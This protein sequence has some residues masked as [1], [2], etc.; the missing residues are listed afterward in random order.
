M[1]RILK[2]STDSNIC[3]APMSYECRSSI[4]NSSLYHA[5]THGFRR[6]ITDDCAV[7]FYQFRGAAG[8]KRVLLCDSTIF[9]YGIGDDET[10]QAELSRHSSN[11]AL[12]YSFSSPIAHIFR[13]RLLLALF[14]PTNIKLVS[15]IISTAVPVINLTSFFDTEPYP[16]LFGQSTDAMSNARAVTALTKLRFTLASCEKIND[17]QV[18]FQTPSMMFAKTFT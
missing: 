11:A 7:S 1:S 10:L 9:R 3:C 5:D 14:I 12:W 6:L 18:V 8:P 13:L 2:I 17:R 16:T 4:I 15:I